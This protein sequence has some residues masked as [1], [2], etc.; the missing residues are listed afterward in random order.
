MPTHNAL[1][2]RWAMKAGCIMYLAKRWQAIFAI[3]V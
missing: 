3:C 1:L 2:M